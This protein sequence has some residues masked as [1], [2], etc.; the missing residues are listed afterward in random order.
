LPEFRIFET[1]QFRRDLA[2]ISKSGQP[3]VVTKLK[4]IVYPQLAAHPHFGP[5]IRKLKGY[6]PPTWRYRIGVWRFFYEID[7]RRRVV[8]M[9]AASRRGSAY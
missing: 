1:E 6:T 9:I 3:A 4:S 7:D 2:G 8:S 5:S